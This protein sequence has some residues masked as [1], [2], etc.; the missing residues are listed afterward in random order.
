[1]GPITETRYMQFE[2]PDGAQVQIIVGS[3]IPA[4]NGRTLPALLEGKCERPATRS[5]RPLLKGSLVV[6]LLAAS[7]AAGHYLGG[8]NTPEVARVAAALPRPAPSSEQH[9]FPDHPLPRE[10][11][12]PGPSGQVS[13]EFKTQLR[14]PPTVISPPG[15]AAALPAPGLSLPPA[16]NGGPGQ[17]PGASSG[18]PFTGA[19]LPDKNPFGL[20][21]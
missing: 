10:A 4:A 14:Q 9:P 6:M 1:M 11:T 21:N 15:Q 16:A 2:I 3:S 18:Q 8:P 20:E 13:A 19:G 17:A 12:V 5:G 7:F